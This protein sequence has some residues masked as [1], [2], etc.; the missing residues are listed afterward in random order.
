MGAVQQKT[1]TW[2]L[3]PFHLIAIQLWDAALADRMIFVTY[4]PNMGMVL[5]WLLQL[6]I[7]LLLWANM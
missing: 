1:H 6:T 4:P 7:P 2:A 5:G 3:L